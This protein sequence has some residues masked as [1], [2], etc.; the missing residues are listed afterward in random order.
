MVDHCQHAD[1]AFGAVIRGRRSVR[2]YTDQPV[3]D[4]LVWQLLEAA[5]WAPSAHN[6]QPW[7]FVW[8]RPG[9]TRQQL[10]A[11]MAERWQADLLADGADPAETARRAAM[12]HQRITRATVII[13]PC[14]DLG[15]LDQF[16]DPARQR[17]EWQ[18]AVQSVALACQNLLL[19]AHHLGLAACWMCAPIF[20]VDV[21]QTALDLPAAW[22]PQALLT[23]GYPPA[24]AATA[25]PRDSLAHRVLIRE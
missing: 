23:I 24:D 25:K 2:Y 16:P 5:H 4:A 11:A 8:V 22:Q 1:D 7:R 18:M 13:L 19:A 15:T 10:A 3:A 14:L 20:C 21:V 6:R 12:S 17:L 9:S